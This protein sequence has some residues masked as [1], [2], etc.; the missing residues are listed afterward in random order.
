M[1]LWSKF[2]RRGAV[3][4]ASGG[5]AFALAALAQT[6]LSHP[7]SNV[8]PDYPPP[9]DNSNAD[10][11]L[12]AFDK[13]HPQCALWTDWHKLCSRT[14]LGG[15][16][17]CR[18][19]REHPAKPS[20][21]FCGLGD[22][23]PNNIQATLEVKSRNRF[24]YLVNRKYDCFKTVGETCQKIFDRHWRKDRPFGGGFLNQMEHPSCAVWETYTENTGIRGEDGLREYCAE[25]GRKSMPSCRS[26]KFSKRMQSA[27][28]VCKEFRE[29]NLC[30][31]FNGKKKADDINQIEGLRGFNRNVV[32][33]EELGLSITRYN[34][35]GRPVWGLYCPL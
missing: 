34:V 31:A 6:T 9:Y 7:A 21:P 13:T 14:G 24:S 18:L 32:R 15:S 8:D 2:S 28:Y 22:G 26:R 20:A 10:R 23:A 29:R 1:A 16:T 4:A 33:H 3:M 12:E 30:S 25:D 5:V 19:D 11:A 17:Y 27:P 35:Q